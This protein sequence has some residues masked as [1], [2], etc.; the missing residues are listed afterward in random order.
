MFQHLYNQILIIIISKEKSK[1]N[2]LLN[3]I[4]CEGY[5]LK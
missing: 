4:E 2:S 5:P 1:K 3:V